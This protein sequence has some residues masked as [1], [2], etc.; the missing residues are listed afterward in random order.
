MEKKTGKAL[1][2]GCS[3]TVSDPNSSEAAQS[4]LAMVGHLRSP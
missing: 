4:L 3:W 1:R 2:G